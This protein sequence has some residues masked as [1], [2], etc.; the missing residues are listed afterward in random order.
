MRRLRGRLV[1]SASMVHSAGSIVKRTLVALIDGVSLRALRLAWLL[2]MLSVLVLVLTDAPTPLAG[3]VLGGLAAMIVVTVPRRPLTRPPATR[4]ARAKARPRQ[5]PP[6]DSQTRIQSRQES[7]VPSVLWGSQ[8]ARPGVAFGNT[9]GQPARVRSQRLAPGQTGI[10]GSTK[11]PTQYDVYW[12]VRAEREALKRA[13]GPRM[14]GK[15][16]A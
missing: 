6:D 3:L 16:N 2:T 10:V 13:A 12:R 8:P 4:S 15:T 14:P 9:M 7:L 5:P 11:I 1:C